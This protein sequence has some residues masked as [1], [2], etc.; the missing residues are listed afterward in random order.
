MIFSGVPIAFRFWCLVSQFCWKCACCWLCIMYY[1]QR[2]QKWSHFS[3]F[4]HCTQCFLPLVSIAQFVVRAMNLSVKQINNYHKLF[5]RI[6]WY[7]CGRWSWA[8]RQ[9]HFFQWIFFSHRQFYTLQHCGFRHSFLLP[10]TGCVCVYVRVNT[11]DHTRH[12]NAKW[13][14]SVDG[15]MLLLMVYAL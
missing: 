3:D 15:C 1:Y 8:N 4:Q 14:A 6:S 2:W 12:S 13:D 10:C 5:M 11:G 7:I 9:S